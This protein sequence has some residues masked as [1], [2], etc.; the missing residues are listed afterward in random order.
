LN[1]RNPLRAGLPPLS[2]ERLASLSDT[3]FGV[4]MTLLATTLVP[5]T[6]QL[7]GS[8]LEMMQTLREPLMAVVLSFAVS[9]VYWLSQQRRLSMTNL[10]TPMETRLHL[11]FLFLIVLLPISTGLFVRTGSSATSVAIFGAHLVL[12]SAANLALWI[13]VHR[14]VEAL[15][16]IVPA[17]FALTLL[18]GAFGVGL[19]R[20]EAAQYLWYSAFA[21][22]LVTRLVYRPTGCVGG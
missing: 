1:A 8:A 22:P 9:A 2:S 15:A 3:M 21:I 12:I 10:L 20:P 5:L 19:V 16:A 4:A 11:V 7:S 6:Q 14:Q 17:A 13:G 18:T